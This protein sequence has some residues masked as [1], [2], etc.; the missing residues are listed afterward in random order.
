MRTDL[1]T[2]QP[3]DVV[4]VSIEHV[5]ED[6]IQ[7]WMDHYPHPY[8]AQYV[9]DEFELGHRAASAIDE[10]NQSFWNLY[11]TFASPDDEDEI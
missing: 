3:I 5:L 2:K 9:H 7:R 4:S 1:G 8:T 6:F 10:P 11:R